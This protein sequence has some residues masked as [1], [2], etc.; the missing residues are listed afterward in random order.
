MKRASFQKQAGPKYPHGETSIFPLL[1]S[2]TSRKSRG[3]ILAAAWPWAA[4]LVAVYSSTNSLHS[5]GGCHACAAELLLHRGKWAI[6]ETIHVH[7]QC[8]C[9]LV[10]LVT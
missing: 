6:P 10:H 8:T 1:I 7:L 3:E 4:V 5:G 9:L 2:I